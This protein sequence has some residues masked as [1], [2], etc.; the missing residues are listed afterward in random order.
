MRYIAYAMIGLAVVASWFV[1][2][3]PVAVGF[4]LLAAFR[5]VFAW[6][7][8]RREKEREQTDSVCSIRG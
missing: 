6:R 4:T 7:E 3:I 8:E 1:T 5:L 2:P